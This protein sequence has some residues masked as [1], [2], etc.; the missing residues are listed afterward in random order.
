MLQ[1]WIY[2][3]WIQTR[4]QFRC[5]VTNNRCWSKGHNSF[6]NT[7]IECCI[8][9][10]MSCRDYLIS[11]LNKFSVLPT[12]LWIQPP[13]LGR[14]LRCQNLTNLKYLW[15]PSFLLLCQYLM[16]RYLCHDMLLRFIVK[17]FNQLYSLNLITWLF[18]WLN[19]LIN[20]LLQYLLL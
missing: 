5:I 15:F 4:N 19:H 20:K 12:Q 16:K 9:P 10:S 3:N 11:M 13:L 18:L 1:F 7:I 6:R 8:L 2:Y 14:L 17:N